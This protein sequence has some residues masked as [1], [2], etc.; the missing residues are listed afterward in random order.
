MLFGRSQ[1]AG[2][3][4]PPPPHTHTHTLAMDTPTVCLVMHPCMCTYVMCCTVTHLQDCLWFLKAAERI[5]CDELD[6]TSLPTESYFV[7]FLRDIPE[8]TGQEADNVE[9]E[10]PKV[11]EQV[12]KSH[13]IRVL[14]VLC[15]HQ[16]VV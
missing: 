12:S 6:G 15:D 8:P 1:V 7:D 3:P 10:A 5:L 14:R 16:R 13:H 4:P 9:M 11:Y 2:P